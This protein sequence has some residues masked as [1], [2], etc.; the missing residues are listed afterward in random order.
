MSNETARRSHDVVKYCV[1]IGRS[2]MKAYKPWLVCG[3]VWHAKL[4]QVGRRTA[5]R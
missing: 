4:G 1:Y 5:S 2:R 3:L